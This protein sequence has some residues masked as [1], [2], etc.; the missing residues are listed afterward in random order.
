[1]AEKVENKASVQNAITGAFGQQGTAAPGVVDTSTQKENVLSFNSGNVYLGLKMV[2]YFD[3][4]AG[5]HKEPVPRITCSFNGKFV[6]TPMNGKWWREFADF[7]DKMA[8]SLEGCDL[9]TSRIVDDVDHAKQVM[10]KFRTKDCC[11][12]NSW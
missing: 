12:D 11:P 4:E 2:S 10:A 6:E 7:V 8:Q 9:A 1:M 5:K 3:E